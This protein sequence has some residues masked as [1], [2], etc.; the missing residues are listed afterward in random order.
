MMI[1]LTLFSLLLVTLNGY[2]GMLVDKTRVIFPEGDVT[3]SLNIMNVN[4]YPSFVQLWVDS[5]EINNFK[6]SDEAPFLL[7]PPIFNLR[8]DEIKSVKVIYNGKPLP[9]DRES[10]YWINIYEVP[11]VK[12]TLSQEQFLLMSMKTQMKV[13]YRPKSL[14]GDVSKAG[15][16]LSCSVR[17][18]KTFSLVCRNNTGYFLSYKDIH[19]ISDQRGY[20]ATA[21]LDLMIKPFSE[22][23]F[24]LV[25]M[26]ISVRNKE[27]QI[28]FSL[29]DDK[30][31][32]NSISQKLS[33]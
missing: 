10:L 27:N 33:P 22:N 5:G 14:N 8:A 31:E 16:S 4:H 30:G 7:I 9:A 11:A 18:D 12:E 24:A 20:K 3:Q 2:A 1:K 21:D 29:I 25:E 26:P 28:D 23:H 17:H 6:Q 32:I 13:I 19:V 15:Q